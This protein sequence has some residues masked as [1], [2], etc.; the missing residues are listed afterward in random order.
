MIRPL[1][2]PCLALV[3]HAAVQYKEPY[4]HHAAFALVLYLCTSPLLFHL[5]AELTWIQALTLTVTELFAY[6]TTLSTSII[7]YRHFF[8]PLRRLP[9]PWCAKTSMW[10]WVPMERFGTRAKVLDRLHQ[11]Y[12]CVVRIGPNCVSINDGKLLPLVYGA[13]SV[14]GPLYQVVSLGPGSY[15]L[16]SE[17]TRAGHAARRRQWDPA[18]SV[19][20]LREYQ[21]TVAEKTRELMDLVTSDIKSAFSGT[22]RACRNEYAV[23]DV[24]KYLGWYAFDLM[25]ELGWGRSFDLLHSESNRIMVKT[26]HENLHYIAPA[27]AVPYMA[28]IFNYST[29]NPMR[30]YRAWLLRAV[31]WRMHQGQTSA[32]T[33]KAHLD[34][35]GHLLGEKESSDDTKARRPKPKLLDLLLDANLLTIAGSDTTSNVLSLAIVELSQSPRI[36]SDLR[37]ELAKVFQPDNEDPSLLAREEATPLLHA[38]IRETLRLWP[39]IPAGPPRS[40]TR[41]VCLPG[42]R[43]VPAG[44]C[45]SVPIGIV[46]RDPSN[47]VRPMEWLPERWLNPEDY[48]PHNLSAYAPF[49]YGSTGCV[50]KGLAWMELRSVLAGFVTRFDFEM[51]SE[52]AE[53]FKENVKD[54]FIIQVGPL[55][56]KVRERVSGA[57]RD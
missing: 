42:D 56:M 4:G 27:G 5:V 15:S 32:G 48:Q 19:A 50:G 51:D 13:T 28:M 44:A 1:I 40:M 41:D 38:V 53:A 22:S 7:V 57:R 47:F 12:G 23:L 6:V 3:T 9:G 14:R 54:F 35:F 20:S 17:P 33:G 49:G 52:A 11:Q 26:I 36:L 43:V 55:H 46:Q 25:G 8:H 10:A 16:Q 24:N 34:V 21:S 29:H 31:Q 2:S 45:L 18:F 30:E 37:K 39:V